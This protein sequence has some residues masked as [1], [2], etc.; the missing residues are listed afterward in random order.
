VSPDDIRWIKPREGWFLNRLYLQGGELVGTMFEGLSLQLEAA[1][2]A[3]STDDLFARLEASQQ[4]LRV[5]QGVD[6]T[7]FR[8]PTVSIGEVEQLR[9]IEGVVRLGKVRRIEPDRIFLD[10]GT[11]PTSPRHLHVHCAAKGIGAAPETPIFTEGRIT[12]QSIRIGLLPF[13]SALVAFVEATRN[14]LEAQN[15]LCPPNRQPN[16]P[17]DWLRG[18]LVGM[19][20]AKLWSKEP[21]I[22]D[23]LERARLNMLR[24]LARRADEPRVQESFARFATHVRAG[25]KNL[26]RLCAIGDGKT[27]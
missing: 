21:D 23:W 7:M 18:M 1:A 24:G 17:L 25:L 27:G 8:G 2:Q 4:L 13:A 15:R 14:D 16:V 19:K 3:A 5:D 6:P 22:A 20:A 10:G 12:L 9:R 11:V 26:E